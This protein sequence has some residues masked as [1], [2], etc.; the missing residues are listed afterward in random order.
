MDIMDRGIIE[1]SYRIEKPKGFMEELILSIDELCDDALRHYQKVSE[2]AGE[3]NGLIAMAIEHYRQTKDL[4]KET[5]E[6]IDG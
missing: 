4:G 2:K 3:H 6:D 1:L 5:V